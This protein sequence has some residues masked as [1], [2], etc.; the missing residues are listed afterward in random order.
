MPD[1]SSGEDEILKVGTRE[2][3]RPRAVCI[4][5]DLYGASATRDRAERHAGNL[6][7]TPYGV[8]DDLSNSPQPFCS[9]EPRITEGERETKLTLSPPPAL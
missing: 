7:H 1:F 6:V 9:R 5:I 2:K 3:M 8:F 4:I